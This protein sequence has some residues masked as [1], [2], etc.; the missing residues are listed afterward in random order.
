MKTHWLSFVIT[1]SFL[2]CAALGGDKPVARAATA[3]EDE[4]AILRKLQDRG[5]RDAAIEKAVNFLISTQ[6]KDGSFGEKHKNALTG[7]TV[8]ALMAAGHTPDSPQNGPKIRNALNFILS[9]M[10]NDGYLGHSDHSRMYGHGICTLMLTEAAGMTRDDALEK[11]LIDACRRAV[12]LILKAQAVKKQGHHNGGWRYEPNSGDSDLSLTGWQTMSLRSAKNI[13]I[14]VPGTAITAA[15]NYIRAMARDGEFSYEG[16]GGQPTLRGIGLL[17]LPV[18][19][20]YD[21]PELAKATANMLKDPPKWQGPWFYYR[22]YYST[23]GMYQMGDEAWNRFHPIVDDVLLKQQK[24][25]GSWPDPPGN[26]EQE[27]GGAIYST[28]MAILVLAVHYHLL[29]IYQR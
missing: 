28:S 10:R 2:G 22:L 5:P 1:A 8:M 19:G 13:G 16:G 20:V 14:D 27:A 21:A 9:Q 24:P 26:N 3:A 15:T 7:L 18:C 25:D 6:N 12:E 23:M 11:R 17:A 29:P 4:A